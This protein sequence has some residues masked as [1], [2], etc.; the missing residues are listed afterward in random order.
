MG[1]L[2]MR[3]GAQRSWDEGYRDGKENVILALVRFSFFVSA[4]V[5]GGKQSAVPTNKGALAERMRAHVLSL[6]MVRL[7]RR[8]NKDEHAAQN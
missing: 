2:M 6:Y 7:A 4:E 5:V 3:A 8:E 1:W